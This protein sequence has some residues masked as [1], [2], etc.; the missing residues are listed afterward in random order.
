MS[1]W[2]LCKVVFLLLSCINRQLTTSIYP[3]DSKKLGN[4]I[5][6]GLFVIP[7]IEGHIKPEQL[8]DTSL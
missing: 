2:S 1:P 4:G 5:P 7:E 3:P 6:A 8:T